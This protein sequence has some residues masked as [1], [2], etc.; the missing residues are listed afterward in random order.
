MD[1][2][3]ESLTSRL[4]NAIRELRELEAAIREL[5][6]PDVGVE[7][8]VLSE[9]R[10]ATDHIRTT[11]WAMQLALAQSAIGSSAP[12][13]F[14]PLLT[15][16]RLRRAAQLCEDL[17]QEIE[18]ANLKPSAE[19]SERFGRLFLAMERLHARLAPIIG[20]L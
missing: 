9:F 8:R 1:E 18:A 15:S 14:M 5:E 4:R 17:A 12:S 19:V 3:K 6:K 11:A 2:D 10:D 20:K 16:E 7:P 13:A